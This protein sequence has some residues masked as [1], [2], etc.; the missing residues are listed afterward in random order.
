MQLFGCLT[1]VLRCHF[2][3]MS[4]QKTRATTSPQTLARLSDGKS[5]AKSCSQIHL[6]QQRLQELRQALRVCWHQMQQQLWPLQAARDTL[7]VRLAHALDAQGDADQE[8]KPERAVLYQFAQDLLQ[9]HC[10]QLEHQTQHPL[11]PLLPAYFGTDWPQHP[12]FLHGRELADTRSA[13]RRWLGS[14]LDWI[15]R[16]PPFAQLLQQ[17]AQERGYASRSGLQRQGEAQLLQAEEQSGAQ[18]KWEEKTQQMQQSLQQLRQQ[19]QDWRSGWDADWGAHPR[20]ATELAALDV[21]G[22]VAWHDA[23]LP[24]APAALAFNA[25]AQHQLQTLLAWQHEGL[26]RQHAALL[27]AW[28]WLCARHCDA[29]AKVCHQAQDVLEQYNTLLQSLQGELATL[30]RALDVLEQPGQRNVWLE[31]AIYGEAQLPN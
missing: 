18:R 2:P 10:N 14:H 12:A 26:L 13:C 8:R 17:I 29:R 16:C 6:Q 25:Q 9:D 28:W 31:R 15:E 5:I 11:H 1:R 19:L 20:A 4:K 21:V 30:Q 22:L 3:A 7:R 23:A 27:H 24:A